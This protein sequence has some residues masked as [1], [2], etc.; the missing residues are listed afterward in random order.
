M[1]KSIFGFNMWTVVIWDKL[2]EQMESVRSIG[3]ECTFYWVTDKQWKS[4]PCNCLPMSLKIYFIFLI[5]SKIL[6][7]RAQVSA[8]LILVTLYLTLRKKKIQKEFQNTSMATSFW[9]YKFPSA[10]VPHSDAGADTVCPRC[11]FFPMSFFSPISL[12]SVD[13]RWNQYINHLNLT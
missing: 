1:L 4:N 5:K 12:L 13:I 3:L 8:E 2:R 6:F 11:Q 9:P 7:F 10:W